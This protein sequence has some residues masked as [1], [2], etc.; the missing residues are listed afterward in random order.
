M[1]TVFDDGNT[2]QVTEPG[3][4]SRGQALQLDEQNRIATLFLNADLGGYAYAL[5]TA[6]RLPDGTF[7]FDAGWI[8]VDSIA[9]ANASRSVEVDR[10]GNVVYG[11]AISTPEYRTFRMAD[12]YTPDDK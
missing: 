8:A 1:L 5:G 12:L 11:A 4:D 6:Q 10:S 2:R 9:G 3:S 7:H